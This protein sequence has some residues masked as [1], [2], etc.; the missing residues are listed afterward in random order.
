MWMEAT[1]QPCS[2]AARLDSVY[3]QQVKN[4]DYLKV[5]IEPLMFLAKHNSS[6]RP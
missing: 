3:H 4:R 5:I 6:M 1:S 2:V